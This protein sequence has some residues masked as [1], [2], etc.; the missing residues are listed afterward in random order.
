VLCLLDSSEREWFTDVHH[1]TDLD[2]LLSYANQSSPSPLLFSI[3]NHPLNGLIRAYALGFRKFSAAPPSVIGHNLSSSPPASSPPSSSMVPPPSSP[4]QPS[5]HPGLPFIMDAICNLHQ[6][7]C[8]SCP[9]VIN[10]P[11]P[12]TVA[13]AQMSPP[14]SPQPHSI[15]PTDAT[16]INVSTPD[17][18]IVG[19]SVT[20][21][22]HV[23]TSITLTSES[24]LLSSPSSLSPLSSSTLSIRCDTTVTSDSGSVTNGTGSVSL[25]HQTSLLTSTSPT[26][27]ATG[28]AQMNPTAVEHHILEGIERRLFAEMFRTLFGWYALKYA[29][30]IIVVHFHPFIFVSFPD[31]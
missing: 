18:V 24:S 7:I 15:I 13:A 1:L 23:S 9:S 12:S 11:F 4:N 30:N 6:L 31:Q 14:T 27:V 19:I 17:V 21:D 25:S 16:S 22:G 26:T 2:R 10:A 28:G 8:Q 29:G 20:A 3:I 5:P